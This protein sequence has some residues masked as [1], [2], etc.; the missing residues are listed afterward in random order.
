MGYSG[1]YHAASLAAVFVALAIGILIGVGLADDV[2]S[3]ASDELEESLRGDLEE[4][5]AEVEDLTAQLELERDFSESAA[6]ALVAD[7][8]RRDQVALVQLGEVDSETTDPATEGV[9][10]AGGRLSSVAI[11]A[12]PPDVPGL[13]EAGGGRF[14]KAKAGPARG[15][16]LGEALGRQLVGAG[17]LLDRVRE[18]LFTRFNG[19]LDDVDRVVLVGQDPG[20][21]AGDLSG[22]GRAFETAFLRGLDARARGTVAVE[23]TDT[24]PTTLS[25]FS[26]AGIPTVDNVDQMPGRVAMVFA[27]L[28]AEG[29]F[30]IK[31]GA[32]SLLPDLLTAP[33]DRSP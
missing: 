25:A 14:A 6:P 16:E 15:M 29:E 9:E 3:G 28:G 5:N 26:A 8:L 23:R 30:G 24:D 33:A 22:E 10:A 21:L 11:L 32:T 4:A 31:E 19:S 13:A 20:D 2:V 18:Q 27:L 17:P 1:R 12:V 7:R